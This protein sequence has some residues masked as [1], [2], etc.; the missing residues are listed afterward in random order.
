MDDPTLHRFPGDASALQLHPQALQALLQSQRGSA[1]VRPPDPRYQQERAPALE[2]A[3]LLHQIL[4]NT[5]VLSQLPGFQ[6]PGQQA[7]DAKPA[8]SKGRATSGGTGTQA[9]NGGASATYASRHQQ[10]E[11]RRRSR[12]NERLEALRRVVP[13]SERANTANFL[14]EVL[15]YVEHLQQ[16]VAELEARLGVEPESKEEAFQH[17][18]NREAATA[19]EPSTLTGGTSDHLATQSALEQPG[20]QQQLQTDAGM[21]VRAAGRRA[22]QSMP[23]AQQQHQQQE[24]DHLRQAASA[25]LDPL[26]LAL[27]DFRSSAAAHTSAAPPAKP[28]LQPVQPLLAGKAGLHGRGGVALGPA[29]RSAGKLTGGRARADDLLP[30][31]SEELEMAAALTAPPRGAS[32]AAAAAMMAESQPRASLAQLAERAQQAQQGRSAPP[33][34]TAAALQDLPGGGGQGDAFT[35][36]ALGLS[37]PLDGSLLQQAAQA[38]LGPGSAL[39]LPQQL[40]RQHQQQPAPPEQPPAPAMQPWVDPSAKLQFH[41]LAAQQLAQQVAQQQLQ[42][43]V[44]GGAAHSGGTAS[45]RGATS[46]PLGSN[47]PQQVDV[48]QPVL[49]AVSQSLSAF[50]S[51]SNGPSWSAPA[52]VPRV[53]P[54]AAHARPQQ[55]SL[56]AALG[57]PPASNA[58][59]A[60]ALTVAAVGRELSHSGRSHQTQHMPSPGPMAP[61]TLAVGRSG[62]TSACLESA[63][64]PTTQ[65]TGVV[66]AAAGGGNGVG[67]SGSPAARDGKAGVRVS[68]EGRRGAAELI[69]GEEHGKDQTKIPGGKAGGAAS[70]ARPEEDRRESSRKAAVTR[71][72]NMIGPGHPGAAD[73][74]QSY[75]AEL[76]GATFAVEREGDEDALQEQL[77]AADEEADKTNRF[78]EKNDPD[79]DPSNP[80]EEQENPAA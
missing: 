58:V 6:D 70:A 31:H 21:S 19:A 50:T 1:F 33:R 64:G 23:S 60:A 8:K 78:Q 47:H 56:A 51:H 52:S 29:L 77:A 11:A 72:Q 20:Q 49:P 53:L 66:A 34:E 61:S 32:A 37:S 65:E 26:G 27:L 69:A 71:A 79:Y 15:A 63:G 46:R 14:E 44:S 41:L 73:Q 55:R 13:H 17:L 67:L 4:G 7:A 28:S 3:Q 80:A 16:R 43:S 35:A 12:I 24:H 40:Q 38:L 30:S 39:T 54:A 5:A 59:A 36:A 76:T 9:A 48:V 74:P 68:E 22:A 57:M 18:G 62:G 45:G 75:D 2:P 25:G 10:A 42:Q